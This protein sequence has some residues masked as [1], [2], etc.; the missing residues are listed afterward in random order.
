MGEEVPGRRDHFA[1]VVRGHVGRHAHRDPGSAVDQQVRERCGEDFRFG[2]LTVVVGAE[3]HHVLVDGLHHQHGG[4]GQAGFGVPHRRGC[5]VAAEGTEVPVSVDQRDPHSEG[6]AEPH[7]RVVDGAVAVGVQLTHDFADDTRAFDVS[8]VG[9]QSHFAHLVEDAPLDRF[10]AVAGVGKCALV[11]DRVG[12]LEETA[13]H[14]LGDVDVDDL[15]GEFFGR[16]G[17]CTGHVGHCDRCIRPLRTGEQF[18]C[19]WYGL[20]PAAWHPPWRRSTLEG[21]PSAGECGQA[22]AGK[23]AGLPGGR[24]VPERVA[25]EDPRWGSGR[26]HRRRWRTRP[27][28]G[29]LGRSRLLRHPVANCPGGTVSVVPSEKVTVSGW[30]VGLNA[31]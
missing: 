7:Q 6:L 8:A 16:R 1:E 11:D 9:A 15:L 29:V 21:R 25:R 19:P 24:C 14:F 2:L 12:V 30:P 20:G 26:A 23:R 13:A 27:L 17:R 5:V 3:V 28:P 31:T 18:F 4:A 10:E 22:T